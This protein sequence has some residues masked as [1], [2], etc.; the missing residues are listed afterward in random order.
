[1]SELT[2]QL[3]IFRREQ[4]V[5]TESLN[6]NTLIEDTV[7][8]LKHLLKKDIS[9][10]V[11]LDPEL[12][13]IQAD[14]GQL[15]QV[16]LNLVFNARDAMPEGGSIR[17]KTLNTSLKEAEYILL[18]VQDSG[19]GMDEE[20]LSHIFEPFFTTKE[21]GKGTGLGLATVYSITKQFN[22]DIQVCS[23]LNEGTTFKI[24]FP[25]YQ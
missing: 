21:T 23:K 8:M 6:L 18:E 5:Q 12:R 14:R 16:L 10:D 19:S 7:K 24:Y 9:L 22:G 17:I 25:H 15:N 13:M 3:L 2:N 11:S 1:M 4:K 20:I